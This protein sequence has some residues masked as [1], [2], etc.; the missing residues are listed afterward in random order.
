[1]TLFFNNRIKKVKFGL[2]FKIRTSLLSF[3]SLHYCQMAT[4]SRI[5]TS[6][7]SSSTVYNLCNR[8]VS[9]YHVYSFWKSFKINTSE[10]V[11]NLNA[12]DSIN[13][14]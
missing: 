9:P 6:I 3:W 12:T 10:S 13:C 1:M 8:I 5:K 2:Y 4:K 14:I 7:H 11:C